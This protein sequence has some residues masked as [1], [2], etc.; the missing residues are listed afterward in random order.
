MKTSFVSQIVL[1]IT[2]LGSAFSVQAGMQA[3]MQTATNAVLSQQQ[4]FVSGLIDHCKK[5]AP[6]VVKSQIKSSVIDSLDTLQSFLDEHPE[7]LECVIDTLTDCVNQN[8]TNAPKL[9]ENCINN[10]TVRLKDMSLT[11]TQLVQQKLS[12]LIICYFN[13]QLT[14]LGAIDNYV[15]ELLQKTNIDTYATLAKPFVTFAAA[16]LTIHIALKSLE[17]AL[18]NTSNPAIPSGEELKTAQIAPSITAPQTQTELFGEI[19]KTLKDLA[20]VSKKTA[21]SATSKIAAKTVSP[22]FTALASD[23]VKDL[24]STAIKGFG[25]YMLTHDLKSNFDKIINYI[26]ENANAKYAQV[27]S[28]ARK[29][30]YKAK[31]SKE[32]FKTLYGYEETKLLLTPLIDYCVNLKQYRGADLKIA[33]GYLFEGNLA[34]GR[35]LSQ[36]LAGEMSRKLAQAGCKA[37]WLVYEIHSSALNKDG[38]F[39]KMLNE[40]LEFGPAIFIINDLDWIYTQKD[41]E[42]Q[43]Y[44]DIINKSARYLN[45]DSNIPLIIC[46]TTQD[47]TKIDPTMLGVHK[48]ELMPLI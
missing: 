47:H 46:A 2:L 5:R 42:P 9:V 16:Y 21:S 34:D 7:A 41:V 18:G 40:C 44:A 35:K 24:N 13:F 39:E 1:S 32:S 33:H 27:I 17:H 6:L 15:E 28:K 12:A 14:T 20:N 10:Y 31:P 30:G 3:G 8:C 36:A 37:E 48:F 43:V 19:L 26:N 4:K 11:D 38:A 29:T 25:A 45:A 22:Q 23:C